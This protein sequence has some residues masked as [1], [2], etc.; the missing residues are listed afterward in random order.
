MRLS[1]IT[2]FTCL[3]R[4]AVIAVILDY[5]N[6]IAT[7]REVEF[8]LVRQPRVEIHTTGS[9]YIMHAGI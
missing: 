8:F 5:V 1:Q 9:L 7:N 2:F 6:R 3:L 4:G